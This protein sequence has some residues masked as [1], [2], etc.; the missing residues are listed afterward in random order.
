M[1]YSKADAI[2][3]QVYMRATEGTVGG[4]PLHEVVGIVEA[5]RG[6][7]QDQ[8]VGNFIP[9]IS[10][11]DRSISELHL[12]PDCYA[13]NQL[14]NERLLATRDTDKILSLGTWPLS[15]DHDHGALFYQKIDIP[16]ERPEVDTFKLIGQL[17]ASNI[18]YDQDAIH[19]FS[20]SSRNLNKHRYIGRL[21]H[22][23]NL[24][25]SPANLG[26]IMIG[27]NMSRAFQIPTWGFTGEA[28]RLP[29]EISDEAKVAWTEARSLCTTG[30][31]YDQFPQTLKSRLTTHGGDHMFKDQNYVAVLCHLARSNPD[32]L[33]I[34]HRSSSRDEVVASQ[35]ALRS[36]ISHCLLG[37]PKES[38]ARPL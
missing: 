5:P 19:I 26:S 16:T 33:N 24:N 21:G 9:V 12:L 32:Y 30:V 31:A 3:F 28:Y 7:F 14:F 38:V 10:S 6:Y 23:V 37:A 36:A 15:D 8:M 2:N 18:N 34:E 11:E 27:E 17:S 29:V 13:G 4:R 25:W 20:G 22:E 1:L 35:K